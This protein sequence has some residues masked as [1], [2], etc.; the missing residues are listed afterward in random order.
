MH[1]LAL[2]ILFAAAVP[3]VGVTLQQPHVVGTFKVFITVVEILNDVSV[4]AVAN[5]RHTLI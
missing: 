2:H 3:P 5:I 4:D 1:K